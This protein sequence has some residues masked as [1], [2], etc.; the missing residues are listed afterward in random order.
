[1][2]IRRL[3]AMCMTLF[4]FWVAEQASAE[5]LGGLLKGIVRDVKARQQWPD[6]YPACD[7]ATVWSPLR[8]MSTNGWRRQNML[9]EFHFDQVTGQLN[10]AGR[11]KVRWI[12]TECP[13]Q[14][15]LI[16]VHIGKDSAETHARL[17]AVQAYAVESAPQDVPPILVSTIADEGWPADQIEQIGR[18]YR[19]KMPDPQLPKKQAATEGVDN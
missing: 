4:F 8:T 11:L 2:S 15:R 17:A 13:R 18:K 7:K 5:L 12:L 9:G 19:E 3:I 16:Y 14:H 10:E 6:P 1:M